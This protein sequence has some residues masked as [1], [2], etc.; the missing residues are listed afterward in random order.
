MSS[1]GE[2]LAIHFGAMAEPLSVQFGK[3]ASFNWDPDQVERLQ[4]MA[5]AITRLSVNAF[6]SDGEAHRARRRVL[7][8]IKATARREGPVA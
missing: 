2:G 1:G 5:D 7:A 8:T 4:T 6:L 3:V